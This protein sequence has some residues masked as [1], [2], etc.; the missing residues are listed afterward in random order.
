VS[1]VVYGIAFIFSGG[2]APPA[3]YPAC[4]VDGTPGDS[5]GCDSNSSCN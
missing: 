3:P 5:L 4:G 1:D 2:A